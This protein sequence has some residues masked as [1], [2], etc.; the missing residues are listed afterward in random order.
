MP[1]TR[2]RT[3]TLLLL[4]L[5]AAA[6]PASAINA[7]YTVTGDYVIFNIDSK[8]V[9]GTGKV[10][11]LYDPITITADSI[12]VDVSE[13]ILKARGNVQIVTSVVPEDP[14]GE[15]GEM[16]Q[17]EE[18]F[19]EEGNE[20]VSYLIVREEE[21]NQKIYVGDTLV[22]DLNFMQGALVQTRGNVRKIYL[23]GETLEETTALQK[24]TEHIDLSDDPGTGDSSIVANRFRVSPNARYEAWH[25]AM[26][27]KGNK[28]I[29]LPYFTNT[30]RGMMP[31]NWRLK[32]ASYSTNSNLSITSEFRYKDAPSKRGVITINYRDMAE[33]H[34]ALSL[35]QQF[36]VN[37]KTSSSFS[38]SNFLAG[39]QNYNLAVNRRRSRYS[40][41]LS[42]MYKPKE[43]RSLNFNTTLPWKDSPIQTSLGFTHNL[44][45]ESHNM[46][47][48]M[49]AGGRSK[50]FGNRK[51]LG[52]RL[53]GSLQYQNYDYKYG[54]G[55]SVTNSFVGVSFFRS[56]IRVGKGSLV[57][58]TI[59]LGHNANT[60][61]NS[62]SKFGGTVNYNRNFGGGSVF[63]CSYSY[64]KNSFSSDSA[65]AMQNLSLSLNFRR[66]SQWNAR[67]A[68]MYNINTNKFSD[69]SLFF[70]HKINKNLNLSS[71]LQ[72]SLEDHR[73]AMGHYHARYNLLGTMVNTTWNK[74]NN[75][76]VVDLNSQF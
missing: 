9:S 1:E 54:E 30:G 65:A 16:K 48:N 49:F 42:L 44:P 5:F 24:L 56:A 35:Q 25:A 2:L 4:L 11:V 39:G 51:N 18:A 73:F 60:K 12:Q 41:N 67:L 37:K 63:N 36:K 40:Q 31:G 21:G 61:G 66:I 53:T 71:S 3:F 72:Y 7:P 69:L 26:W 20:N 46:F 28:I 75:D 70:D 34:M 58:T 52:Y 76:F 47:L 6:G 14:D 29:T 38:I 22:Y 43:S 32:K 27:I 45:S 62:N 55:Y 64:N 33:R 50:Y 8:T 17:T 10:Q 23:W 68:S 57:S 13:H 59:N 74:E 19:D 15:E